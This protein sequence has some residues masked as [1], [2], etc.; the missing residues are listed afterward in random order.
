MRRRWLV[1]VVA[2]AGFSPMVAGAPAPP[3]KVKQDASS[4]A[5]GQLR[6]LWNLVKLHRGDNEMAMAKMALMQIRITEKH[7]S[8]VRE[9]GP[10]G[11]QYEITLDPKK[12]PPWI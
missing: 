11:T 2:L 9:N 4:T 3:P 8:F 7:F 5:T 6:G 10:H 12:N 1:A